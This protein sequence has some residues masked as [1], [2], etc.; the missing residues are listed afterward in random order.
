LHF[1]LCFSVDQKSQKQDQGGQKKVCQLELSGV[2][3]P[4]AVIHIGHSQR[5]EKDRIGGIEDIAETVSEGE[6]QNAQLRRDSKDFCQRHDQ[7]DQ[8]EGF[9]RTG[10]NKEVHDQDNEINEQ[11]HHG[12]GKMGGNSHGVI[13]KGIQNACRCHDIPDGGGHEDHEYRRKNG[14]DTVQEGGT[15]SLAAH[16]GNPNGDKTRQKEHDRNDDHG[17][18]LQSGDYGR[19]Q[20]KEDPGAENDC[21]TT[22]RPIHLR[23]GG[24]FKRRNIRDG[25]L[26]VL[27]VGPQEK[28]QKNVDEDKGKQTVQRTAEHGKSR[29][30]LGNTDRKGIADTGGK[31]AAGGEDAHSDTGQAVP[32]QTYGEGDDD[33][34][35]GNA[36]FK[37]THHG[38]HDHKEQRDDGDERIFPVTVFADDRSEHVMHQTALF[39]TVEDTADHQKKYE[40][41][42]DRSG[43]LRGQNEDRRE[44]PLRKGD[45][46]V[47]IVKAG[48]GIH[49]E[50]TVGIRDPGKL[51]G[52]DEKGQSIGQNH[53]TEDDCDGDDKRTGRDV[54]TLFGILHEE[55]I[56]SSGI[57]DGPVSGNLGIISGKAAA[58]QEKLADTGRWS[59]LLIRKQRR[60]YQLW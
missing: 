5:D 59:V 27:C 37:G 14:E 46:A 48:F 17:E 51:T 40:D 52:G 55:D 56:L 19:K 39:Q 38:A 31:A 49:D 50:M 13:Q 43:A 45:P 44:Q 30:L 1:P 11:K 8:K 22:D 54:Q 60:N 57:S 53:Q 18:I 20:D 15:E 58:V 35:H 25:L 10:G 41:G 9:C 21:K 26:H 12:A 34:H 3:D 7:R 24:F 42:K 32:A 47:G 28:I 6:G 33:R 16:A 23:I 29:K 36:L 2:A 4:G